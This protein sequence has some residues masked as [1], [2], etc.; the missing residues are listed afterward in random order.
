MV[1]VELNLIET[2]CATSLKTRHTG[3]QTKLHMM[4]MKNVAHL[5]A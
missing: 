4:K 1:G 3:N 2:F 5:D